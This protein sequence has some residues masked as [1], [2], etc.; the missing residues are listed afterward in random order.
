MMPSNELLLCFPKNQSEWRKRAFE[1]LAQID[2]QLPFDAPI[3][4]RK[5]LLKINASGFHHGTS[6]G[7]RVW[8]QACRRYLAAYGARYRNREQLKGPLI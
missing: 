3:K 2:A 1:L 8:G 7:R 5:E 4:Q 6:W